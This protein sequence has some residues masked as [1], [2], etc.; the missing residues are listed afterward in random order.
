[1]R[2]RPRHLRTRLTLWYVSVLA[3]LLVLAWGGTCAL[4]F[5]QLRG[6]LD[7]FAIQEIETVEGLLFF[8][9]DGQLRL[10]EDYHNHPESKDVIDRF[11]EVRSPDGAVLFRNERLGNRA[12]GADASSGRGRRGILGALGASVRWNPRAH[13]EPSAFARRPAAADPPG[14]QRGAVV[15]P[16]DEIWLWRR[17]S[18]CRWCSRS[19]G[20]PA[21][22]W[23]AAR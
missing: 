12:L 21:M 10:R 23:R 6:Q 1:M 15:F 14:S 4:L 17:F 11:L 18:Y 3:A 2:L 13:G 5:F 9:P 22:L 7:H 19:P 16:V 8:A 20:L